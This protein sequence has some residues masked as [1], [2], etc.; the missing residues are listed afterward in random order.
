MDKPLIKEPEEEDKDISS[1]GLSKE[2]IS[3]RTRIKNSAKKNTP[4]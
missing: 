2:K 1:Q 4:K 3:L